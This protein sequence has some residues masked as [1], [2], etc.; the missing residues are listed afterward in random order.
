MAIFVHDGGVSLSDGAIYIGDWA[1]WEGDGWGS[2]FDSAVLQDDRQVSCSDGGVLM[3]DEAV[4]GSADCADG[5]RFFLL[6]SFAKT[7]VHRVCSLEG[8]AG[9]CQPRGY[10]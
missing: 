8:F 3:G 4:F 10:E 9:V 7:C 6:H 5:R 1:V 2:R